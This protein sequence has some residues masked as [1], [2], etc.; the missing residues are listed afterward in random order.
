MRYTNDVPNL[1]LPPEATI[2]YTAERE[3]LGELTEL[4]WDFTWDLLAKTGGAQVAAFDED[5]AMT[6]AKIYAMLEADAFK[7]RYPDVVSRRVEVKFEEEYHMLQHQLHHLLEHLDLNKIPGYNHLAKVIRVIK[8]V[9]RM[10]VLWVITRNVLTAVGA[11]LQMVNDAVQQARALSDE[12]RALL[13]QFVDP[14]SQDPK[15]DAEFMGI[16]LQLSGINLP[17]VL[18]I[19][20][21]LDTLSEFARGRSKLLPDP[22]GEDVKLRPIE[23]LGELGKVGQQDLGLPS[24]LRSLRAATGQFDIR[25]PHTKRL[26]K[27]LLFLVV[28]GSGSMLDFRALS[29]SRAVG[30]LLNRLQAVIDGDAE[31]F[32]RFFDYDLREKE[33]HAKDANSAR[34]LLRIISDPGQYQGNGTAFQATLT[35]ASSRVGELLKSGELR[36]PEM[37][38]VTDGEAPIPALSVLG[39]YTM[40]LVQVGTEEVVELSEF[41]RESGGVSVYAGAMMGM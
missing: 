34:E 30:V 17:E 37:V 35:S 12:D 19:A 10:K 11:L 3:G 14:F 26:K 41:A 31:L 27:Q 36:A 13:S 22:D 23:T 25:A 4:E 24:A 33:Y 16:E 28:D 7:R 32:I 20:R 5:D 29:A 40:H 18:R 38:L 21:H 9:R 15:G 1:I 8:M 39:G 2:R 6:D